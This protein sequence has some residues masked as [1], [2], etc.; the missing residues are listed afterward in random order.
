[1]MHNLVVMMKN[2]IVEMHNIKD[3]VIKIII[4]IIKIQNIM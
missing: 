1:M 4:K 3:K 2:N